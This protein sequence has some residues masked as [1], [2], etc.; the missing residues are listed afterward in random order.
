MC[1]FI[2]FLYQGFTIYNPRHTSFFPFSD[3]NVTVMEK[4]KKIESVD[5]KNMFQITS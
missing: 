5:D 1:I 4:I 2:I 3:A